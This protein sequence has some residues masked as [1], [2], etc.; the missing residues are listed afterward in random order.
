MTMSIADAHRAYKELKDTIELRNQEL[1]ET[2]ERMIKIE[3]DLDKQ[4][5]SNQ[6]LTAEIM[7]RKNFELKLQEQ[8][9]DLQK[10]LLRMPAG[11]GTTEEE[12]RK[13]DIK[14]AI[15]LFLRKS[16]EQK[17]AEEREFEQKYLRTDNDP[18]GGYLTPPEY[19]QE[20]LKKITEISPVRQVAR[21]LRTSR[22]SLWIPV[23]ETLLQGNWLGEGVEFQTSNSKYGL[24]EIKVNMLSVSSVTSIQM[25]QDSVFNIEDQIT[26]DIAESFAQSEGLAFVTGDGVNK[27]EGLLTNVGTANGIQVVNSGIADAFDG[28]SLIDIYGQLKQGYNPAYMLNRR[29]I[30]FVRKLKDGVGR[31]LW[32]PGLAEGY[33]NTIDGAPY[34]SAIDVQDIG[35][36]AF[37]VLFGDFYRG[38]T[39]VDHISMYIVRDNYTQSSQGK[40]VFNVLRRVGGMVTLPEAIKVLKCAV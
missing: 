5:E 1:G 19:Y 25:V 40:I 30:A 6:K 14:K 17:S 33:P 3:A 38:Y 2:K 18:S 12:Q 23:R 9:N 22:E 34:V 13:M 36:N 37:P 29:T 39:I 10:Q 4:E 20:I 21:I 32:S 24:R 27:P 35:V 8:I 26:Q 15:D 11:K 7:E 31:Y 16:A 28:D